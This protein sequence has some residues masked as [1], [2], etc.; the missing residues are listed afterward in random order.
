MA[1]KRENYFFGAFTFTAKP[2]FKILAMSQ[3]PIVDVSL[4]E[5]GWIWNHR[6]AVDY[7]VYPTQ[8]FMGDNDTIHLTI[9]S[10]DH[11][12]Y[13]AE[14]NIPELLSTLKSVYA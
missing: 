10:N 7:C 12:A 2:P 4:Y 5:G 9:G 1:N 3:V 8:I 11:N 6:R 13:M 14:I